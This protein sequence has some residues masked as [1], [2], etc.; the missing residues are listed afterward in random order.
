MNEEKTQNLILSNNYFADFEKKILTKNFY[1]KFFVVESFYNNENYLKTQLL[2]NNDTFFPVLKNYSNKKRN[3]YKKKKKNELLQNSEKV[4]CSM[5][6]ESFIYR[7]KSPF[8]SFTFKALCKNSKIASENVIDLLLKTLNSFNKSKKNTFIILKNTRGGYVCYSCGVTGFLC[9]RNFEMYERS[10]TLDTKSTIKQL[11][12][13]DFSKKRKKI[14]D[15]YNDKLSFLKRY[16]LKKVHAIIIDKREKDNNFSSGFNS[17]KKTSV[18]SL[19]FIFSAF[20]FKFEPPKKIKKFDPYKDIRKSKKK[21]RR[22]I[23]KDC[24]I[25]EIEIKDGSNP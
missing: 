22:H 18:N 17:R 14:K 10:I 1:P 3:N 7:R 8:H 11:F 4:G 12:S 16:P 24:V 23:I 5:I 2:S 20:E 9:Q 13:E 6:A 25:K 19:L 21:K 15:S